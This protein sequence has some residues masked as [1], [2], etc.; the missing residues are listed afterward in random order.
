MIRLDPTNFPK[1]CSVPNAKGY[2]RTPWP[3]P[4]RSD[5]M[6]QAC[7]I[8]IGFLKKIGLADR[9]VSTM[10]RRCDARGRSPHDRSTWWC[11]EGTASY[12]QAA[13]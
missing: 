9:A 1:F 6:P 13:E 11:G 7:S 5:L 10:G 2:K 12:I 4:S 8:E 3:I